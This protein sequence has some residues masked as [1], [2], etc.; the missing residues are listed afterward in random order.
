MCVCY[1]TGCENHRSMPLTLNDESLVI[2]DQSMFN[3]MHSIH[4]RNISPVQT[5]GESKSDLC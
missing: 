3:L 2:V 1:N 5:L 4:G